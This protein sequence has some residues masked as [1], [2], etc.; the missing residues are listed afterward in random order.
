LPVEGEIVNAA[1]ILLSGCLILLQETPLIDLTAVP[2]H[3]QNSPPSKGSVVGGLPG[4]KNPWPLQLKLI[5]ARVQPDPDGPVVIYEVELRNSGIAS[6]DIP[7]NPSPAAIEPSDRSV[8]SYQYV[9]ASIALAPQSE[10]P[11][12]K[13][14][15]LALYGAPSLP[16]TQTRLLPGRAIRIRAK[17]KLLEDATGS[18]RMQMNPTLTLTANFSLNNSSVHND[19]IEQRQVM[20]PISSSN[21]VSVGDEKPRTP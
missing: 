14:T 5:S 18:S 15:P 16:G 2:V 19:E 12:F 9:N 13:L 11:N 20:G 10:T 3:E 4:G 6:I 1:L 21:S 7:I 8:K 17:S